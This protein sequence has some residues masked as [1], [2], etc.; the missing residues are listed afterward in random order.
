MKKAYTFFSDHF[1][2][3]ITKNFLSAFI[4]GLDTTFHVTGNDALQVTV[5][6]ASSPLCMNGSRTVV[7][8][9][10]ADAARGRLTLQGLTVHSTVL[11]VVSENLWAGRGSYSDLTAIPSGYDV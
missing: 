7:P 3:F 10:S 4:K 6:H 9:W 2:G 5:F 1:I 8:G 11:R